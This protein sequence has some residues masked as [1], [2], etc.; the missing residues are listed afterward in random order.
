VRSTGEAPAL[1]TD[2]AAAAV[3]AGVL[4]GAPST[5][6]AL[7]TRRSVLASTRAIAG[8][9]GLSRATPA[10]QLLAGAAVHSGISLGW[11]TVAAALLPRRHTVFAGALAGL[12]VGVV[13]LMFGRRR[14]AALAELPLAPQLVDHAAF[15]ALAGAVIARR[16]LHRKRV[17][18]EVQ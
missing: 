14:V 4:S 16:R 13:D 8:L 17:L 1:L 10:S 3:V 15:G 9:V 7:L 18:A 12:A 2:A 11:S 6:H 5:V